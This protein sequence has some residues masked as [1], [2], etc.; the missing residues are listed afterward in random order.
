M[1]QADEI[2][3]SVDYNN[4]YEV[5]S[6]GRVRRIGASK[7]LKI[8][9]N[10]T[11]NYGRVNVGKQFRVHALVGI[12]FLGKRPDG[13]VTDHIDGDK[14]NNHSNNLEY[15]TVKENTR[16]AF[17]EQGLVGSKA[18]ENN[19]KAVLTQL[20]VDEI[21]QLIKDGVKNTVIAIR[22]GIDASLVSHIKGGRRWA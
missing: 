18:G 1:T 13:L 8:D 20:K 17:N 22:F 12:A 10:T 7:C 21:K 19:G 6:F 9:Y 15:V 4:K 5:S 11:G 3:K 14:K 2:W 16:R